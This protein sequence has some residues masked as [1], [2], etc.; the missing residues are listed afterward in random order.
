M[1]PNG[2]KTQKRT[3]QIIAAMKAPNALDLTVW[4]YK[5]G[6]GNY[7]KPVNNKNINL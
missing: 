4:I 2:I 1:S 7:N 6:N 3:V 5:P